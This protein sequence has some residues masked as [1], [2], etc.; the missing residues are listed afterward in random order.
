MD[1]VNNRGINTSAALDCFKP[2]ARHKA[3]K[4][5]PLTDSRIL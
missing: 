2:A 1:T 4:R 5:R 3:D